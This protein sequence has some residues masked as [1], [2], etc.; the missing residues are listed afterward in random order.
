M[1]LGQRYSARSDLKV[2]IISGKITLIN[3]FSV[4]HHFIWVWTIFTYY[5]LWCWIP[6]NPPDNFNQ[7]EHNWLWVL[8][9]WGLF[10][11]L[12][13]QVFWGNR[14]I[15]SSTNKKNWGD[16][17][18]YLWSNW[19]EHLA[20]NFVFERSQKYKIRV[21]LGSLFWVVCWWASWKHWFN[22]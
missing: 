17:N 2:W 11:C 20:R 8:Q 10:S 18:S 3:D 7:F 12:S 19:I 6:I 16:E 22:C 14:M 13:S 5:D 15:E 1:R 4:N 21:L 9:K